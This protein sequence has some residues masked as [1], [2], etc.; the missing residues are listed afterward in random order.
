MRITSASGRRR[1][2]RALSD[3]TWSVITLA[4][5]ALEVRWLAYYIA[6][7]LVAIAI[8]GLA[9]VNVAALAGERHRIR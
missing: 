5:V 1:A 7:V 6:D 9:L 4:L 2:R 8:T 3:L